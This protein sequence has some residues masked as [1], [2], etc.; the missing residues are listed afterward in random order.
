MTNLT[1]L[2]NLD[3]VTPSN[4]NKH[5]TARMGIV[6][7]FLLISIFSSTIFGFDCVYSVDNGEGPPYILNLTR[8]SEWTLELKIA[9]ENRDYFYTP[10]RNGLRCQQGNADF[11][12]N[13]A[14]YKP[15]ENQCEHYLS[16][17]NKERPTYSDSAASF[18]FR[19]QDGELCSTT[20]QPRYLLCFVL[21]QYLFLIVP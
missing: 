6:I 14:Q 1:T 21:L 19:Y 15:G 16:V 2:N 8:V 9:S 20:Q 18:A 7:I 10:C 13:V 3:S 17:D 12:N 4:I 5:N 11:S